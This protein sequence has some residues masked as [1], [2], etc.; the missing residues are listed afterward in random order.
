MQNHS[1]FYLYIWHGLNKHCILPATSL[2]KE[3]KQRVFNICRVNMELHFIIRDLR[4]V[5]LYRVIV[6]NRLSDPLALSVLLHII[7]G[8]HLKL[9]LSALV[10]KTLLWSP[11]DKWKGWDRKRREREGGVG[12]TT[13]LKAPGLS[14]LSL[15]RGT[16]RHSQR[17]WC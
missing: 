15:F 9:L 17:H 14:L 5:A 12:G 11:W 7:L 4:C 13:P 8:C 1:W 6:W 10:Y 2:C 3:Q 16:C